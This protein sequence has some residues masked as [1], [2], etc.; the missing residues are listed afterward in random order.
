MKIFENLTTPTACHFTSL[1]LRIIQTFNTI[2]TTNYDQSFENT[3]KSLDKITKKIKTDASDFIP[4]VKKLPSLS[5]I[6]LGV[7]R[8]II[9]IHGDNNSDNF[10]L[11]KETYE[12]YYNNTSS[13][14]VTLP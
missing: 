9:H 5:V 8:E 13:G 2:I 11:T 12:E 4:K 1:H 7:G 3:F 10:I 6:G 14:L